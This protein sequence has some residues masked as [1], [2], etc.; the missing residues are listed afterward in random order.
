MTSPSPEDAI[1]SDVRRLA[2]RTAHIMRQLLITARRYQQTRWMNQRA[3]QRMMPNGITNPNVHLA[4]LAAGW[5]YAH[6]QRDQH[7]EI[8]QRWD[9][10]VASHGIDPATLQA[11]ISQE[12]EVMQSYAY[13]ASAEYQ[14]AQAERA[15]A[16][17]ERAQAQAEREQSQSAA[18]NQKE[19]FGLDDVAGAALAATAVTGFASEMAHV[20]PQ[21]LTESVAAQ[22]H[23]LEH[24][25]EPTTE[26]RGYDPSVWFKNDIA[27]AV[28]NHAP[29]LS[30][31]TTAP[32]PSL[33]PELSTGPELG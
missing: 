32:A 19:S 12:R 25:T 29:D 3:S 31:S 17:Q 13:D 11:Q 18:A 1:F 5:A 22:V 15:Q 10:T 20:S 14:N 26:A 2:T 24:A 4:R 9:R 33:G 16:A 8:A 6:H 27:E 23:E 21:E 30:T 28:Q 7:P